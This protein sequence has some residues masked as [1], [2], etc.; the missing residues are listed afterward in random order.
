M[1]FNG[2]IGLIR[3][4]EFDSAEAGVNIVRKVN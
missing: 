3:N 4:K 2:N 1:F